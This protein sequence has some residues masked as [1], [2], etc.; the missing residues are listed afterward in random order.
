MKKKILSAIFSLSIL[1]SMA[2]PTI[3]AAQTAEDPYGTG[4][5]GI[6]LG[7]NADIK[8]TVASIIN[9]LLGFLGIIAVIIILAGGFK[10]MTAGGNEDKVAEARKMIIQGIIG[11]V[12]IF[13]SWAIAS[14]VITSLRDATGA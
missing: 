5:L 1:A 11:L 13:A 14:F 7:E 2:L 3:V 4:N 8:G 12:I 10:W 9:I 6:N